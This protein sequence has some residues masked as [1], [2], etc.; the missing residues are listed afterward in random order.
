M[1]L[2]TPRQNLGSSQ[3]VN[4][5]ITIRIAANAKGCLNANHT[6]PAAKASSVSDAVQ[7]LNGSGEALIR[8]R[9]PA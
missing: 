4:P 5:A 7:L 2:R 1:T 9:L 8:T 3:I 6:V